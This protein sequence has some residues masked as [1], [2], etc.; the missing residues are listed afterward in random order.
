MLA[1][2]KRACYHLL[3][4][5]DGSPD[6]AALADDIDAGLGC[7]NIEY[8]DKRSSGRLLPLKCHLMRK[9]FFE[10]CKRQA[11]DQGQREGQYKTLALQYRADFGFAW[12]GWTDG[13]R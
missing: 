2:V 9:G 13:G 4:E 12:E 5:S 3:L 6:C 8:R 11:L 1:D 10:A 7:S